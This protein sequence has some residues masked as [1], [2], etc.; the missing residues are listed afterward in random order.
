MSELKPEVVVSPLSP[1]RY[2]S[3]NKSISER[4][5]RKEGQVLDLS[6]KESKELPEVITYLLMK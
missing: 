3:I 4:V 5:G 6:K 2:P 1:L